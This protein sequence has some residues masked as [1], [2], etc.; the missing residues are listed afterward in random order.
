MIFC[1]TCYFNPGYSVVT[2]DGN[3]LSKGEA[4]FAISWSIDDNE[5]RSLF[6]WRGGPI[7]RGLSAPE[8]QGGGGWDRFWR[9]RSGRDGRWCWGVRSG[10][11]R[12]FW[13]GGRGVRSLLRG[14]CW[15]VGASLV[16]SCRA[17]AWSSNCCR[18]LCLLQGFAGQLAAFAAQAE[19]S[20]LLF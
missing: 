18:A 15:G 11:A 16:L 2:I 3:K 20:A 4:F 7:W 9:V 5:K 1:C 8:Q 17:A 14:G 10:V 13:G 19:I 6:T 12:L